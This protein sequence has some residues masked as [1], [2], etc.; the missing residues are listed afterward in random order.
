MGVFR[1]QNPITEFV[2]TEAADTYTFVYVQT[3]DGIG[4]QITLVKFVFLSSHR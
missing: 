1:E 3:V 2:K 4:E